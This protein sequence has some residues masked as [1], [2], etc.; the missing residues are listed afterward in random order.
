MPKNKSG[1][2]HVI[3]VILECFLKVSEQK[4]TLHF[5]ALTPDFNTVL[6][7]DEGRHGLY[8]SLACGFLIL[9]DIELGNLSL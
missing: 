4:V 7:D 5:A 9:V 8:I 3:R 6:I 2:T 1:M